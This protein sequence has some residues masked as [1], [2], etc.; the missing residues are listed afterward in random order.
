MFMKSQL[1]SL[2][3]Y[4]LMAGRVTDVLVSVKQ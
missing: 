4:V 2:G 3:L 1:F